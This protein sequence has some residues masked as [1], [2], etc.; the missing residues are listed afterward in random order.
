MTTIFGFSV[1]FIYL[2]FII[3]DFKKGTILT[4][5]TIQFLAYLGTG[6][7]KIKIFTLL[8]ACILV[9]G[10]VRIITQKEQQAKA[11]PLPIAFASIFTG[12]C[13][14]TTTYITKNSYLTTVLT[15]LFTFFI[16]PYFFWHALSTKSNVKYAINVLIYFAFFFGIYAIIEFL[17]R[18]NPLFNL[19]SNIFTFEE[20]ADARS[21]L[22]YGMHRCNSFFS[23]IS[24]FGYACCASYYI[25]FYLLYKYRHITSI[26]KL[27]ILLYILPICILAT[28]SRAI[29]LGIIPI[30]ISFLFT[31][32]I[33]KLKYTKIIIAFLLI[34][35][36]ITLTLFSNILGSLFNTSSVEGSSTEMRENQ[37][38]ICLYYFYQSPIW[39]NGKMYLWDTVKYYNWELL[40]AE[41]IWFGL[42]VDYGIMGCISF[43]L[44]ILCCAYCLYKVY[45]LYAY[46][47]FIYVAITLFSPERGYEFNI[48]ITLTLLL[49]K[50]HQYHLASRKTIKTT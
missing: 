37:L 1:F 44:L 41:S 2:F 3:K 7:P 8:A 11:Y 28:G 20:F 16:F 48:L 30:M 5:L 42:M 12:V 36:P 32:G 49:I 31:P 29:Y 14:L 38:D 17:L 26:G 9:L 15:N 10:V 47:P 50:I 25:F 23:Y 33:F 24:P 34:T 19:L 18:D 35:L 45:P 6:I 43:V 40:G 27:K 13:Y 39:G 22:R 21:D 4:A 46:F